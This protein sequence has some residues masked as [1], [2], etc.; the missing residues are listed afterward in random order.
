MNQR[1][2]KKI[3]QKDQDTK[4][5]INKQSRQTEKVKIGQSQCLAAA[6]P[7]RGVSVMRREWSEES[8][9]RVQL[10][11]ISALQPAPVTSRGQPVANFTRIE[12]AMIQNEMYIVKPHLSIHLIP[13]MS[14]RILN[15]FSHVHASF[16][17]KPRLW[18]N[19]IA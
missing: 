7:L 19:K 17:Q 2:T 11:P 6:G 3:Y 9:F 18:R 12:S 1:I 15:S 10:G 8:C 4:V 5:G 14:N 16:S 13:R